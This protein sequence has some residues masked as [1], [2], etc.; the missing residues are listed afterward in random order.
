MRRLPVALV[1]GCAALVSPAAARAE[2][3]ATVFSTTSGASV[4][5]PD[6]GNGGASLDLGRITLGGGSSAIVYVSGLDAHANVPVTFTLVDPAG[7]PFTMMSAEILDPLSDGFDAL[8]PQPQPGYVPTGYST[9][10][11]TDGLSFAWNSGLAR[12]AAFADGGAATL[13]VDEDSNARDMLA[14][15]GF[16]G[17]TQA[18][19]TFGLRDNAGD[20]G[21][22]LR[23]SV[24]G[25]A[26]PGGSSTPEPASLLLLGTAAAGLLWYGRQ[27]L[28]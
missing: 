3:I 7:S 28:V 13:E 8:D 18:N 25:Q 9:S 15:H 10:N 22:L 23:L 24:D 1:L 12:S 11:N 5:L 16:S 4:Q 20:R 14:F 26:D 2:P 6:S 27:Q 21:F 19:V 17:D